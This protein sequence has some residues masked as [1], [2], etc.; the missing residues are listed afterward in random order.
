MEGVG[1]E[2]WV[3]GGGDWRHVAVGN[4]RLLKSNGGRA[5]PSKRVMKEVENFLSRCN[6]MVVLYI[7]VDDRLEKMIAL[8]GM[9][10]S[11]YICV[12]NYWTKLFILQ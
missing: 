5:R 1:V 12:Y 4:E 2:G 3:M 6:G 11:I 8:A 10:L 9:S 7:T